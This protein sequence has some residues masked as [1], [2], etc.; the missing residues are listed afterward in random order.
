MQISQFFNAL[1][2][3]LTFQINIHYRHPKSK[4]L[5]ENLIKKITKN[6]KTWIIR[7]TN[8]G[9]NISEMGSIQSASLKTKRL[10]DTTGKKR[11]KVNVNRNEENTLH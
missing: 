5:I 4:K 10:E 3:F 6:E 7:N 9:K 2:S 1:R 8:F 11:Y